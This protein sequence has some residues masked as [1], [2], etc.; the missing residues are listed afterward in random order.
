MALS[1]VGYYCTIHV[2]DSSLVLPQK[3]E[4]LYIVG[5]RPGLPLSNIS[6]SRTEKREAR[7]VGAVK[8]T[9]TLSTAPNECQA[10]DF[11]FTWPEIEQQEVCLAD[12]LES[13]VDYRYHLSPQ[14]WSLIKSS[15][16]VE[17]LLLPN[18]RKASLLV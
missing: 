13:E 1:A 2:Y 7:P 16:Y 17:M 4:R 3:R 15:R 5:I 9:K 14:A 11:S 10:A 8:V 6:Q 12:V 18:T